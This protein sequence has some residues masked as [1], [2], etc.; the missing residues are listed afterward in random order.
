MNSGRSTLMRTLAGLA[1][2]IALWFAAVV[3]ARMIGPD[4]GRELPAENLDLSR[5]EIRRL[6][7]LHGTNVIKIER[8]TVSILR[9][10]RWIAVIKGDRG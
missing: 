9:D 8:D 6:S 4:G 7:H 2:V 5:Q 1:A 3:Y 10:G